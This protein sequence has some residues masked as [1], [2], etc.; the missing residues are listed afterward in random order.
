[1]KTLDLQPLTAA[2]FAP[3]GD[4]IE[5]AGHE[6]QDMNRGMAVRW[7]DLARI[8]TDADGKVTIGR[9][10]SRRYPQPWDLTLVERH[11]LGSQAFI[12]LETTPFVVVVAEAGDPPKPGALRGFVTDGIQGIHYRH[13]VWHAP[14][15]TPFAAM[16]FI[17]VDRIGPGDNCEEYRLPEG[18]TLRISV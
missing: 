4:V 18:E 8:D 14:L 11:P 5:T 12:P 13:G 17:V 3:Y 16:D 9:V 1:M 2:A 7:P 10:R 15:L 6:A